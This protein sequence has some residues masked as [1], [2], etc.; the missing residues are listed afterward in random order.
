MTA[1]K[2]IYLAGPMR[3]GIS[4]LSHDLT[5]LIAYTYNATQD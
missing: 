1:P 2:R 4:G 3:A 5:N